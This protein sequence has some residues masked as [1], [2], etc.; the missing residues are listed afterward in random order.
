M[1]QGMGL[2]KSPL[3]RQEVPGSGMLTVE[4]V[5]PDT[6]YTPPSL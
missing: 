3:S 4:G 1:N 5:Y 2:K 6:P